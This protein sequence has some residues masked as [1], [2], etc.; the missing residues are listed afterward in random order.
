MPEERIASF[1]VDYLQ[2]LDQNG[3]CDEKLMPRLTNDEIKKLYEWMVYSRIFDDVALKL[4]REGR[5]LTYASIRGQEAAQIGPA[6]AMRSEDWLFPAFRE[7]GAMMV[8]G[9]TATALYQ[10]WGGD[11]RGMNIPEGVNCF[12]I[13]IPVGTHIPHAV[14]RAWAS[15]LKGEKAVSVVFFGDGA[16]SK[17][18]FH[19]GLNFAGVFKVPLVAVIQNN[20]WA[21]SVPVSRQTASQTLAQKT[22]S[23]GFTGMKVDGNDVFAMYRAAREALDHARSGKGPIL[24][25]AYTYRIQ[26]HTTADDWT[27]YRSQEEVNEWI[28]KDPIDRLRKYMQRKGLWTDDYEKKVM[29]DSQARIDRA[30]KE[31]EA[32]PAPELEDIFKYTYAEMTKN[33]QDQMREAL[34]ED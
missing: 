28:K 31:M 4:Q 19:E 2:I 11:E 34:G 21:I 17:A 20:Q 1:E 25:E 12:T 7:N 13:S 3:N 6:F 29:A 9:I 14:G 22:I 16:T 30:V 27:K 33:L 5:M 24:I 23:Y 18:D 10:Y 15:K 26:H 8:K 32:I